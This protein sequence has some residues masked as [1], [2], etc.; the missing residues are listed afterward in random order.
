MLYFKHVTQAEV[1]SKIKK[2][3][4]NKATGHDQIPSKLLKPIAEIISRPLTNSINRSIDTTIFPT[5]LKKAEVYPKDKKPDL[6]NIKNYRPLSILTSVSKI[7]ESV[8]TEQLVDYF[9]EIFSPYLSAYRKGYSC[10]TLLLNLV[11]S[12]KSSFDQNKYVGA[13]LMDLSKAF[14]CLSPSILLNKLKAYGLSDSATSLLGNYLTGRSQRVKIGQTFSTW[15][16]VVRGVPQ[17]SILGPLLFNIFLNDIFY[18]FT[19]CDIHNYADDNTISYA[20][21]Q[22]ETVKYILQNQAQEASIWFRNNSMHANIDKFQCIFLAPGNKQCEPQTLKIN[23]IEI[24]SEKIV[25]L[26]G[27]NIDDKLNFKQHISDICC[28]AGK[29]LNAL[30]RLSKLL[31]TKSKLTIFKSFI[32]SNFNYCATVW[33]FCGKQ[34]AQKLEKIQERALRFVYCDYQSSYQSLLTRSNCETLH[35]S[36]LKQIA[37]EVFKITNN[38]SPVYLKKYFELQDSRYETRGNKQNLKIGR[39]NTQKYGTQSFKHVGAK[40]WNELPNHFKGTL[41]LT[42]FKSLIDTWSQTNCSCNFCR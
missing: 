34:D 23:D 5:N 10:N 7:F 26:L 17:G 35:I 2:L 13:V 9:E 20:H 14:D 41:T 39:H 11:E 36:R 16:D 37:I 38:L 28:K 22:L 15:R 42:E 12:W 30:R 31:D 1:Y 27:I 29:Q 8:L 4:T 21:Q 25:K 6:L 3:N 32:L 33:H 40:I 18:I 19:E 24:T